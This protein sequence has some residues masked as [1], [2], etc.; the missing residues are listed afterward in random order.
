MLTRCSVLK[1]K[2]QYPFIQVIFN[3]TQSYAATNFLTAIVILM[4]TF[5]CV[6]IMASSSRQIFAFARDRGLPFSPW[7]SRVHPTQGVPTNAV[8]LTTTATMLL[9]LI[10]IGSTIAFNNLVSLGAGTLMISYI[11][12]IGCFMWRRQYG[13]PIP[14]AKFS[15]GRWGLPINIIS[16]CFMILVFVVAFFPPI[17]LP[18]LD[19]QT[20]NWAPVVFVAS[21]IWSLAY[22][23]IW[24]RH[25]YEGPVAFV[26]KDGELMEMTIAAQR[27]EASQNKND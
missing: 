24:G 7:L 26:K 23:F 21:V 2:T 15:L 11:V 6:T 17:P 3:V 8:L 20:M 19:A 25:V 9:S 18:K 27:A 22:Y 13:E 16:M 1:T 5:S 14:P 12:C 10:N 4:A